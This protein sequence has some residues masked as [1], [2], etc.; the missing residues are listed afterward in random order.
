[1]EL[2]LEELKKSRIPKIRMQPDL[3]WCSSI[4]YGGDNLLVADGY[5]V[6]R[7]SYMSSLAVAALALGSQVVYFMEAA[8]LDAYAKTFERENEEWL[9][10]LGTEWLFLDGLDG[11]NSRRNLHSGI[12]NLLEARAIGGKK[13]VVGSCLPKD[14]LFDLYGEGVSVIIQQYYRKVELKCDQ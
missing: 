7:T 4:L 1:M 6:D 2:D 5:G 3:T 10:M 12:F 11:N 9:V 13:T 14:E 8:A